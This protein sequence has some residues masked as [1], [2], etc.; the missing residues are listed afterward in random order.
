MKFIHLNL[1]SYYGFKYVKY[2]K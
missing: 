2:T 1:Y